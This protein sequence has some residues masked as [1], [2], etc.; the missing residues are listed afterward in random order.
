MSHALSHTHTHLKNNS[1]RDFQGFV[2]RRQLSDTFKNLWLFNLSSTPV[3]RETNCIDK[4]N[5]KH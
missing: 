4:N 1:K 2:F 3:E 5:P